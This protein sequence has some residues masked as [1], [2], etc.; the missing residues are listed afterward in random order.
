MTRLTAVAFAAVA[1]IITGCRVE[2]RPAPN[3]ASSAVPEVTAR[4]SKLFADE[5]LQPPKLRTPSLSAQPSD[6]IGGSSSHASSTRGI[7]T[8]SSARA[9]KWS[10]GKKALYS[11]RLSALE[12]GHRP[13]SDEFGATAWRCI[14][15]GSINCDG[16][17]FAMIN[18]CRRYAALRDDHERNSGG[19]QVPKSE[20]DLWAWN[21]MDR[22]RSV[23]LAEIGQAEAGRPPWQTAKQEQESAAKKA[24]LDDQAII[25]HLEGQPRLICVEDACGAA[26]SELIAQAKALTTDMLRDPESARY[27]DIFVTSGRED[28]G[29]TVC[30]HIQGRNGFGGYAQPKPFKF[31][32]VRAA[33][34]TSWEDCTIDPEAGQKMK[35]ARERIASRG[36]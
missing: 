14:D 24:N 4:K 35:A 30:G 10:N 5:S 26:E 34:D 12:A 25:A 9:C 27:R 33:I 28:S 7:A 2:P 20:I 15:N 36:G 17:S 11:C 21:C 22:D 23:I 18:A 31:D 32:G 1:L 19:R 8:A 6:R 13:S 16:S 29:V 3:I